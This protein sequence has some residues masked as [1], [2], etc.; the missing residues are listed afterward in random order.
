MQQLL[1]CWP[2][3]SFR[4]RD[5]E[6]DGQL[7]LLLEQRRGV[8]APQPLKLGAG[9]DGL[10]GL[11]LHQRLQ[12]AVKHGGAQLYHVR[13]QVQAQVRGLELDVSQAGDGAVLAAERKVQAQAAGVQH[14]ALGPTPDLPLAGDV[15]HRG[16][17]QQGT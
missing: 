4:A 9:G 10:A 11:G 1:Q 5:A 16:R 12:G 14:R 17:T 15:L 7:V 6:A 8:H 3:T 13:G 2:R